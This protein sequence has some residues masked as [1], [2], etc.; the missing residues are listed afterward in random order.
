MVL[1][2]ENK[3]LETKTIFTCI[4]ICK[5]PLCVHSIIYVEYEGLTEGPK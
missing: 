3:I 2:N 1:T 5:I 4:G